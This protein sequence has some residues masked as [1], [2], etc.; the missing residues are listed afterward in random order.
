[1][2]FPI[3]FDTIDSSYKKF[4]FDNIECEI[5]KLRE[6][7]SV[8][9]YK[10]I[11]HSTIIVV[12][13]D[14]HA[15]A[16][17][18]WC[19]IPYSWLHIYEQHLDIVYL[20]NFVPDSLWEIITNYDL[21]SVCIIFIN[22]SPDT[23]SSITLIRF[24]ESLWRSVGSSIKENII[25]STNMNNINSDLMECVRLFDIKVFPLSNSIFCGVYPGVILPSVMWGLS[26]NKIFL[27]SIAWARQIS[28]DEKILG[29]IC[30]MGEFFSSRDDGVKIIYPSSDKLRAISSWWKELIEEKIGSIQVVDTIK[31]K[32]H[33]SHFTNKAYTSIIADE[34][35]S[36]DSMAFDIPQ[37]KYNKR[38]GMLSSMS[39]RQC[40]RNFNSSYMK[41][42]IDNHYLGRLMSV[43]DMNQEMNLSALMLFIAMEVHAVSS[44]LK[45]KK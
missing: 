39:L 44:I 34:N 33:H 41:F 2:K 27:S 9:E 37:W 5:T 45:E 19:M 12:G 22:Y 4:V 14:S 29:Y 13:N 43:T 17:K 10:S 8:F 20:D 40:N 24:I 7:Y 25:V 18:A 16:A 42:M 38:L 35:L 36:R 26:I 28:S 11:K 1:M 23:E 15:K 21:S 31:L 6:A 3:S 30:R 32:Y